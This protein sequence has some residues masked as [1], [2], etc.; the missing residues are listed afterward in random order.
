MKIVLATSSL[1]KCPAS[2]YSSSETL[3]VAPGLLFEL[4]HADLP[5]GCDSPPRVPAESAGSWSPASSVRA[6]ENSE[7]GR[8][9]AAVSETGQAQCWESAVCVLSLRTVTRVLDLLSSRWCENMKP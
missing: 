6:G 9:V 4:P 1:S 3:L 7:Q 8:W 5:P 2:F